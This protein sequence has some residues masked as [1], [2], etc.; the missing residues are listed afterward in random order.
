MDDSQQTSLMLPFGIC[1]GLLA[2]TIASLVFVIGLVVGGLSTA[3]Y[4]VRFKSW[5]GTKAAPKE[6]KSKKSN[7][8]IKDVTDPS[9]IPSPPPPTSGI[10]PDTTTFDPFRPWQKSDDLR[11][12]DPCGEAKAFPDFYG[13]RRRSLGAYKDPFAGMGMPKAKPRKKQTDY[14]WEFPGDPEPNGDS[15]GPPK[16]P[17]NETLDPF[18]NLGQGCGTLKSR[19]PLGYK[20]FPDLD[21]Y[22]PLSGDIKPFPDVETYPPPLPA[23]PGADILHDPFANLKPPP[24]MPES[25]LPD[26]F[27][28]ID[29]GKIGRKKSVTSSRPGHQECCCCCCRDKKE[30]RHSKTA[31]EDDDGSTISTKSSLTTEDRDLEMVE[32]A[33]RKIKVLRDLG[34]LSGVDA[35][36]KEIVTPPSTVDAAEIVRSPES[37]VGGQK[38]DDR[39]KLI[40]AA[41]QSLQALLQEVQG[42]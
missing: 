7:K 33:T 10:E 41:V 32:G 12:S 37:T 42:R 8:G 15:V 5:L 3:M 14:A 20:P 34:N 27:A 31:D 29:L 22:P 36:T 24:P 28:G 25:F 19:G 17:E 35:S 16:T 30:A 38:S 23:Q 18:S 40:N 9:P 21:R 13:T 1:F 4:L 11:D 2:G 39:K 26:P 6:E